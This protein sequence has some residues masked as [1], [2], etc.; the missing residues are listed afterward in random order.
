MIDERDKETELFEVIL[1]LKTTDEV[2][3]FMRDICTP[4]EITAL[5]DRWHICK[6]LQ[7]GQLS[8]RE[9]AD[10]T[11]ASLATITRVA[12]FLKDENYG[13]YRLALDRKGIC[14]VGN[15]RNVK[16]YKELK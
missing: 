10:N 1:S 12:R 7:E 5:V 4:Q 3:R 16:K 15:K 6:K 2:A 11:G 8:Y 9:I 14:Q 13:G